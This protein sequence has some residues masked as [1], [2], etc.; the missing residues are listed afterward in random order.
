MPSVA[1]DFDLAKIPSLEVITKHLSPI[2]TS[3]RY[4]RDGYVVE[5]IGPITLDQSLSGL[6]IA[7]G[8]GTMPR[9]ISGSGKRGWGSS[10]AVSP[11]PSPSPSGTP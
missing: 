5:S 4:D 9:Q 2:V 6:A 11:Q 8:L 10:P 3:Q 1:T 7:G